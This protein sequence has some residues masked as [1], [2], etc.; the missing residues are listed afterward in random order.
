MLINHYL[1]VDV[2]ILVLQFLHDS[3]K[4]LHRDISPNNILYVYDE[5]GKAKCLLID[6]DYAATVG[7]VQ[8]ASHG[9][10]T[11]CCFLV[12]SLKISS[13]CIFTCSQG[14]P[15][16]MALEI[17]LEKGKNFTHALRHDLESLLYVVI[18]MCNHMTAAGVERELVDGNIPQIRDWCNM[19]YDLQQLG[20]KKLSHITDRERVVLKEFTPYWEDFKP[21]A[22]RLIDEFF[23]ISE[24]YPNKITPENMLKILE[25][26]VSAVKEPEPHGSKHSDSRREARSVTQEYA[27]LGGIKGD[28]PGEN[29]VLVSKRVKNDN[30]LLRSVITTNPLELF[31]SVDMPMA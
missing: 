19:A 21:F 5:S 26:A 7:R 8:Q 24:A 27:T 13:S 1:K 9:F 20:H 25:D 28:R 30:V 17:M 14:T 22:R 10:R 11:V 23:P 6:F 16:F 3:A 18:W 2:G 15:P 4:V 29:I 31:E 12:P